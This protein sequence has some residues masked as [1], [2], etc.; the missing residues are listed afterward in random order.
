MFYAQDYMDTTSIAWKRTFHKT[1]C[2]DYLSNFTI[3]KS[4]IFITDCNIELTC[5]SNIHS[6]QNKT[7]GT[8]PAKV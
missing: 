5:G 3:L 8:D 2:V 1:A 6:L 7:M 4:I